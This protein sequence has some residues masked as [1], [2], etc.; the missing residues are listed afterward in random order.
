MYAS[1]REQ[2]RNLLFSLEVGF[3]PSSTRLSRY[4]IGL[5]TM[6]AV[7][8]TIAV[9][10]LCGVVAIVLYLN[11]LSGELVFD[12]RAAIVENKDVLPSSPWSNL[13]WHDFWGDDLSHYKSHKSFRPLS[14]ASFKLNYHLHQLNVTGYHLVNVILNA[15]V[16]YLFVQ[17]CEL[18]FHGGGWGPGLAGLLF[19]SHP[20]HT[21]AV[22]V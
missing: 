3:S 12:D 1:T 15:L 6:V 21:E 4:H 17:V 5:Y 9:R 18:V 7:C 16:C 2:H 20:V 14:T 8:A 11:T 22:S 19:A 13:L 10:V